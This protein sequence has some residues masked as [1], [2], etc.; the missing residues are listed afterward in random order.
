MQK[1]KLYHSLP[2]YG[3][4]II[5]IINF[6]LIVSVHWHWNHSMKKYLPLQS[7]IH[8]LKSDISSAHL[9]LE[10]AIGGDSYIDIQEDVLIPLEHSSMHKYIENIDNTLTDAEDIPYVSKLKEIDMKLEDFHSIAEYRWEQSKLHGIGSELDQAFD[11]EFKEILIDIDTISLD[12]DTKIK[13]EIQKRKY[14]FSWILAFFLFINITVF[15]MLIISRRRQKKY[16]DSLLEEKERAVIT[17]SSIG[18]SV[19]TTDVDGNITFFNDV[20][21]TLTEYSN[22]E[23]QGL[24]IDSVLNLY[25]IKTGN[26][27]TTPISDVLHKGMT[28]LISNGTKLV[29]RSGKEY[30]ISDSAAA[31]KTKEG[32]ILGTVLVFQN[33]TERHAM[34]E[35][36]RQSEAKYKSLIE[37][38]KQ[39]Y[40]FYAHDMDGVF[41][42]VSNSLTDV[43]GYSKEAFET[44]YSEY[45]TDD[46]MNLQVEKFTTKCMEGEQQKPYN[47]SIY[48]SSGSVRYL[49]VSESPVFNSDG[50]VISIEGVARDITDNYLA[51]ENI[52]EQKELLAYRAHHDTLTNLPNRQLFLDRLAQSIRYAQ[53]FKEKVAVLFIDLDHFKEIND[54]LGHHV[55]DEVL[56]TVSSTLQKQ[57]RKTDT[58]ARL[59]GDEFIIILDTLEDVNLIVDI[60]KKLMDAM[61][62]PILVGDHQLYITLSIGVSLYPED[63]DVS[64]D[65][66]RNA[67]AAMYNAKNNGRNTYCFY[68]AE[69][70]QKAFERIEMETSLRQAVDRE[71]FVVYYHPQVD[72]TTGNVVGVEA[73]IRW[74]HPQNGMLQPMKFMPLAEEI[75]L[76]IPIDQWVM[77]VGMTQLVQ[78][79]NAGLNPGRLALNLSIKQLRQTNFIE[80]VSA[81]LKETGCKPEWISFEVT[82]TQIMR[83]PESSILI[84]QRLSDMGIELALDDFGTGYSSLSY[85]KRLPIDKL[86]IDKSFVEG[87]P[88][89]KEDVGIAKALIILSKSLGLDIIAEGVETPEQNRFLVENGCTKIQGYL[90]SE[91]IPA[92]AVEKMLKDI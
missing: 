7:E 21:Q 60:I 77:K 87:L 5:F 88:H 57:I 44:H 74:N 15:S 58:L 72:A 76:I 23:V 48:H 86:K 30:I 78:W 46:P 82:E 13:D 26:K 10:E 54:S 35:V 4:V 14:D 70:T 34:D 19:I 63:G 27:I 28:K 92:V 64:E 61:N 73:L 90:Y 20:A 43:L 52:K 3:L 66:L 59:G 67:D 11:Q 42:Y 39:H 6:T 84:L 40:F 51:Q 12:I 56:K 85:L 83:N 8:T 25:N 16:H 50:E 62:E 49:E 2:I 37:N 45:L 24:P 79:Y 31:V 80:I 55:G 29:N 53:R 91:P 69:M 68:T 47:L 17:L 22:E 18:D 71:E 36:L 38:V 81:L 9:W 33:D 89:N 65:L 41:N 1:N 32:E 75:G